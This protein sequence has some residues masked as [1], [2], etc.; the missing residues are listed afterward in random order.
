MG[1][2]PVPRDLEFESSPSDVLARLGSRRAIL[3][4]VSF[5][6]RHAIRAAGEGACHPPALVARPDGWSGH[7]VVVPSTRRPC[8]SSRGLGSRVLPGRSMTSEFLNPL[9]LADDATSVQLVDAERLRKDL[10]RRAGLCWTASGSWTRRRLGADAGPRRWA[11]GS[12]SLRRR[13]PWR[14]SAPRTNSRLRSR[15]CRERWS[16]PRRW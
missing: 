12:G 10:S 5:A 13:R 3:G 4:V 9:H 15:T 16:R 2:K 6:R 14:T 1:A 7:L 8:G 11:C